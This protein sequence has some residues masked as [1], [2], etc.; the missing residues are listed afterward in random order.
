MKESFSQDKVK[1]HGKA[2]ACRGFLMHYCGKIS[3]LERI[4]SYVRPHFAGHFFFTRS[5][6]QRRSAFPTTPNRV[7]SAQIQGKYTTSDQAPGR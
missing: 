3:D 2:D 5:R 4:N 7:S 1:S 6:S